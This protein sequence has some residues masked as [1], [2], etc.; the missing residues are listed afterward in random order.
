MTRKKT[1]FRRTLDLNLEKLL[2]KLFFLTCLSSWKES[3]F[4]QIPSL[5]FG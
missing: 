1:I 2:P 5:V 3:Y 4:R